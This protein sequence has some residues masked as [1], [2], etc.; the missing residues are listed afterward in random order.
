[1]AKIKVY[2]ASSL[3]G[4]IARKD[5]SIDWL[6]TMGGE[7]DYGYD[8][9]LQNVGACI[10]GAR[11]YAECQK[12]PDRFINGITTYVVSHKFLPMDET[13]KIEFLI[14]NL[15]DSI[16]R[17][18]RS[19]SKDIWLVGGG[20]LIST[21]LNEGFVDEILHFVAPVLLHEGIPLYPG[22]KKDITL[23]L[24]DNKKYSSGMVRLHYAVK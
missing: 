2:I 4:Y 9:F 18:R 5:D 24:L 11:T 8:E 22:L 15:K 19:T 12:H 6:E 23:Q 10:M 13:Q 20:K 14:G 21:F 7:E 3:D 17:I 16:A 1:M